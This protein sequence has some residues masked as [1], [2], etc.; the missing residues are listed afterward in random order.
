MPSQGSFQLEIFRALNNCNEKETFFLSVLLSYLTLGVC[1]II[2]WMLFSKGAPVEAYV[3][4]PSAF[5]SESRDSMDG[6]Y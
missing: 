1:V 3:L 4:S 2:F 5:L 6:V